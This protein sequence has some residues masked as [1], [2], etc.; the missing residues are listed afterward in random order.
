MRGSRSDGLRAMDTSSRTVVSHLPVKLQLL[1]DFEIDES[2][3]TFAEKNTRASHFVSKFD[4][5]CDY[6]A[7]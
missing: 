4:K 3:S 6:V 1:S 2:A 7:D 5:L